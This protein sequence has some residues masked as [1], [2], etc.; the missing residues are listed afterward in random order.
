MFFDTSQYTWC[1]TLSRFNILLKLFSWLNSNICFD[2]KLIATRN[3]GAFSGSL[4][5]RLWN[6]NWYKAQQSISYGLKQFW[7]H[8]RRRKEPL[9]SPILQR[10][11]TKFITYSVWTEQTYCFVPYWKRDMN[12]LFLIKYGNRKWCN[13]DYSLRI[14][15]HGKLSNLFILGNKLWFSVYS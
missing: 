11:K 5:L 3:N 9:K 10:R 15:P 2:L 1:T 6:I 12:W 4:R 8:R 14:W 7:F 13:W